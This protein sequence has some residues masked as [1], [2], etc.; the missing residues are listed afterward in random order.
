[1]NILPR[2]SLL[3]ICVPSFGQVNVKWNDDS[4]FS[5]R[6]KMCPTIVVGP[7]RLTWR[8]WR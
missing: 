7:F 2:L 1:M 5:E 4:L 8:T 6:N 3:R